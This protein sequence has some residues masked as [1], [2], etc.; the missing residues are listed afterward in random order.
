[1]AFLVL[2]A[3]DPEQPPAWQELE[4]GLSYLSFTSPVS[5]SHGNGQIDVLR[6][7]PRYFRFELLCAAE[8]HTWNRTM[9]EWVSEFGLV[10]GVNAGMFKIDQTSTGYM[11]NF[12]YVNNPVLAPAYQTVF[13]CNALDSAQRDARLIDLSCER[14]EVQ[15]HHY[16]TFSQ[17]IRMMDCNGRNVWKMSEKKWSMVVLGEDHQGNLL[18][19]FVRSPFRVAEYIDILKNLPLDLKSLMCLEGGPESS[20]CLNHP[21]LRLEKM[22]SYETG[23][24]ESDD[25]DRFW[26]IPNVIGIRRREKK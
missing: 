12:D 14:W 2:F 16:N 9:P 8:K 21:N 19:I 18:F 4:K 22:G 24:F 23:F 1:M 15:R 13:A 11:K 20:F 5:S 10:A 6:I 17:C 3:T 25:N 26:E 7:D